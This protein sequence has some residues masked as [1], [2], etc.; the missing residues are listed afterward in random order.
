MQL[1]A[2]M[3]PVY[4]VPPLSAKVLPASGEAGNSAHNGKLVCE[5]VTLVGRVIVTVVPDGAV[6]LSWKV[7]PELP[8][9]VIV[10]GS[11]PVPL[12]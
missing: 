11:Q 1:S 5:R 4:V 6:A 10:Y 12:P 9:V 2:V 3:V 7:L 8:D